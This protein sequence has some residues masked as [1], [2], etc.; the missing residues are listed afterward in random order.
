MLLWLCHLNREKQRR[1]EINDKF[2][3]LCL[4]LGLKPTTTT[5][6]GILLITMSFSIII[7][8]L[9]ILCALVGGVVKVVKPERH[10]ILAECIS[11]I[12]DLQTTNAT[13]HEE[14]IQLTT[15]LLALA[16]V[17]QH[18]SGGSGGGGGGTPP[19]AVSPNGSTSSSSSSGNRNG[20]TRMAP[21]ASSIV[22]GGSGNGGIVPP[23]PQY[24]PGPAGRGAG[25]PPQQGRSSSL[26]T[27]PATHSPRPTGPGRDH[28]ASY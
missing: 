23:M 14:K 28:R 8:M 4:L 24:G 27:T 20:P 15:E 6:S 19:M 9:S 25:P 22:G 2:D 16:S 5:T 21:A 1:Q 12:V 3:H 26:S 18:Q 10:T 17:L 11:A 7:L 13:L